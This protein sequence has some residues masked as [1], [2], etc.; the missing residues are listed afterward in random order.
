M[1]GACR[2]GRFPSTAS[3]LEFRYEVS[4]EA[5]STWLGPMAFA[6]MGGLLVATVLT[7]IFLPALYA[8]GFRVREPDAAPA[9]N[10]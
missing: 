9:V 10:Q 8:A 1:R 6:M 4:H 7:L 3:E 5:H 2:A